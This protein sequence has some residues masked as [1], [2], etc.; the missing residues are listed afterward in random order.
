MHFVCVLNTEIKIYCLDFLCY[1]WSS[2]MPWCMTAH[3][4]IRLIKMDI[5]FYNAHNT[6]YAC[7]ERENWYLFFFIAQHTYLVIELF[8]A[9][10]W[11]AIVKPADHVESESWILDWNKNIDKTPTRILLFYFSYRQYV[12][13]VT[14]ILLIPC[15]PYK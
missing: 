5:Y 12:L 10:K 11:P 14:S 8:V 15:N 9:I 7:I 13:H 1:V 6:L 3:W 4:Y 2:A